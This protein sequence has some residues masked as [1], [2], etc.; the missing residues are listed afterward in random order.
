MRGGTTLL[1][2]T[3]NTIPRRQVGTY[4][5]KYVV[6]WILAQ[7]AGG[8]TECLCP[9]SRVRRNQARDS[10]HSLSLILTHTQPVSSRLT[11]SAENIQVHIVYIQSSLLGLL[12]YSVQSASML[13]Q[14]SVLSS[15]R[16][17]K[18]CL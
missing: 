14:L 6:A 2:D 5:Y 10:H 11:V 7:L 12:K 3:P 4:T 15:G 16:R 18:T 1:L 8:P 9:S 17:C 13:Q